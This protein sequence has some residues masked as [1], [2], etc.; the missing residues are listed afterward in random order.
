M[1]PPPKASIN[2]S[3]Y[4][5]KIAPCM[6]PKPPR[7]II[8]NAFITSKEPMVDDTMKIGAINEAAAAAR[9]AEIAKV[10]ED[11]RLTLIPTSC[12][13]SRSWA[14]A[15][16]LV[17]CNVFLIKSCNSTIITTATTKKSKQEK[18]YISSQHVYMAVSKIGDMQNTKNQS[19]TQSYHGVGASEHRPV[20]YLLEKYCLLYTSRAHE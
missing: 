9:A 12:A 8:T 16:M 14:S 4:P 20:K 18:S 19:Q 5:P 1:N 2:P 6:L 15:S 11:T 13:P 3:I 10:M 7:I 17:P